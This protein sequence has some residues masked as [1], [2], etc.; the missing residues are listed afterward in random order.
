MTYK[1]KRRRVDLLSPLTTYYLQLVGLTLFGTSL[2]LTLQ[3]DHILAFCVD[4]GCGC[5]I[6]FGLQTVAFFEEYLAQR[7]VSVDQTVIPKDR[8]LE[9]TRCLL[10]VAMPEVDLTQ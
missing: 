5:G 6:G 1:N 3:S 7:D 8:R 9:R 4:L 10:G 2:R